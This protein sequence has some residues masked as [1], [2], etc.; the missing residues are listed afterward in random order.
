[1][2]PGKS[3][4]E[5]LKEFGICPLPVPPDIWDSI[6]GMQHEKELIESK[7]VLPL[8]HS[9]LAKKHGVTLPKA[10]LL[11]GPPGTG[12]T[13]FSKGIASKLNWDFIEVTP[14]ELTFE[15]LDR[16]ALRLRRLFQLLSLLE[17][18]VVFLD[19]FEELGLRHDGATTTERMVSNEMLRQLPNFR[20]EGNRLLI[21][22]TNNIRRLNPALLRVGRFD[23]ILPV[24]PMNIE[25]RK[26]VFG[27]YLKR[28][29]T[30]EIDLDTI[31]SRTNLFA[32][33]D[34]EAV[35]SKIAQSAFEKELSLGYEHKVN[36][37][38]V[39][40]TIDSHRPIVTLQDMQKFKEDIE[41]YC[42]AD[43]CLVLLG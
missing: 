17:N 13:T 14:G 19:E 30:E 12:K 10:I 41:Q 42:R 20:S 38:D 34:I 21:C 31:A 15:G 40:D 5:S 18:A 26:A 4:L 29:N 25:A 3:K 22:A 1:M 33:A 2:P 43:Y 35:C 9:A 6:A 36:T 32:P 7:I 39:L 16:Q 28:L 23:Y 27:M 11:F 8:L 37:Q 24:G